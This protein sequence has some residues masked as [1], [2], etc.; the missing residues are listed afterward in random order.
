MTLI[1]DPKFKVSAHTTGPLPFILTGVQLELSGSS[2]STSDRGYPTDAI[3]VGLSQGHI[4]CR[5]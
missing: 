2:S 1:R 4:P 5:R 3:I